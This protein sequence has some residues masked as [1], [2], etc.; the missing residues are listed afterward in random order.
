LFDRGGGCAFR[1]VTGVPLRRQPAFVPR[2][3]ADRG[4]RYACLSEPRAEAVLSNSKWG[5]L[6]L[7]WL[8]AF[9]SRIP[10]GR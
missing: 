5:E 4:E 7:R 8:V 3:Q 9:M 1:D 10:A 6:R 2:E